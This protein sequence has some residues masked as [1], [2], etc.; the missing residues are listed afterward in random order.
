MNSLFTKVYTKSH[1]YWPSPPYLCGA[2]SQSYLKCNLLG[3]SPHF[4]PNKTKH[5]TLMLCFP[6][7]HQCQHSPSRRA[8]CDCNTHWA[9]SFPRV[10]F[11]VEKLPGNEFHRAELSW[12]SLFLPEPPRNHIIGRLEKPLGKAAFCSQYAHGGQKRVKLNRCLCPNTE[13]NLRDRVW[14]EVEKNSFFAL[15]GKGVQSRLNCVFQPRGSNKLYSVQEQG[16][17]SSWTFF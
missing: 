2:V 16:V 7:T 14:S 17:I 5:E 12:R 8:V 6:L 13:L 15:P 11:F 4:P 9:G 3:Y 10:G 1:V